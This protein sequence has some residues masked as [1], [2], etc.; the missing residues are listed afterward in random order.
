MHKVNTSMP[1]TEN[2]RYVKLRYVTLPYRTVL[3]GTVP[4]G[5][6]PYRTAPHRTTK[7]RTVQTPYRTAAHPS[8]PSYIHHIASCDT[9]PPYLSIGGG[10]LATGQ[11][12]RQ[13]VLPERRATA[14]YLKGRKK[15]EQGE[16]KLGGH[17]DQ[18][19]QCLCGLYDHYGGGATH[20]RCRRLASTADVLQNRRHRESLSDSV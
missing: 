8:A 13:E 9:L 3:H 5:T 2:L 6:V 4:H 14:Q 11:D 15:Q 10:R 7:H 17:V 19:G 18:G 20:C 12:V 16:S 1:S